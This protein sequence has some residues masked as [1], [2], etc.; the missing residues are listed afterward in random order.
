MGVCAENTEVAESTSLVTGFVNQLITV[1]HEMF[2]DFCL[3][4]LSLK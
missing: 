2:L 4:W 1:V 3:F